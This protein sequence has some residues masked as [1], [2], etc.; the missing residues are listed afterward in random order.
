MCDRGAPQAHGGIG[1]NPPCV[2]WVGL[3][4]RRSGISAW[5]WR[6]RNVSGIG[7]QHFSGLR[8]YLGYVRHVLGDFG[9]QVEPANKRVE[10]WP[11]NEAEA[12]DLLARIPDCLG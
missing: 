7:G 4:R 12:D 6:P 1:T 2:L 8:Q 11:K 10:G 9:R 3:L 5:R